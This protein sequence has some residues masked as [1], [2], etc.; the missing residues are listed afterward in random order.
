[1]IANSKIEFYVDKNF[2]ENINMKL[3][4]NNKEYDY[5]IESILPFSYYNSEI[6]YWK[7]TIILDMPKEWL[8]ENNKIII[9]FI[10]YKTYYLKEITKFIKKGIK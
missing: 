4:I 1:M 8:I 10:K 5:E 2:F 3:T 7:I 9:R 6:E